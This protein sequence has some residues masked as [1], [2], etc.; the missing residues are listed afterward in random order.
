M[1]IKE[2]PTKIKFLYEN[3][4][5]INDKKEVIF[6]NEDSSSIISF[7]DVNRND[8]PWIKCSVDFFVE[9]ID[10]LEKKGVIQGKNISP[11]ISNNIPISLPHVVKKESSNISSFSIAPEKIAKEEGNKENKEDKGV[12]I[13]DA[14]TN[15]D[16]KITKRAVI[17]TRVSEDSN[18]PLEAEKTGAILRG[19]TSE[20]TI[21]SRHR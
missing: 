7:K 19:G 4:Y 14:N 9:V 11:S 16:D 13:I 3:Q 18:D 21:K 6:D 5:D 8:A 15:K 20:K 10:F 17:R 12:I 1:T 2:E